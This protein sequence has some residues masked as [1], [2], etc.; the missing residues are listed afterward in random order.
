VKPRTKDRKADNRRIAEWL[1]CESERASYPIQRALRAA[2]RAAF[3]WPEEATDLIA[4]QRSLT[5][6][7]KVGPFLERQI[8]DWLANPPSEEA[9]PEMRQGFLT[10]TEAQ[11]ILAAK[12]EWK[13]ELKGDLQ[14]HTEWSDGS[15]PVREMARAAMERGYEYIAIT[16]HAKKLKIAGGITE[17]ELREQGREIEAINQDF[18]GRFR[19]LR[20][21][22]LNLDT[23]GNGDMAPAALEELD[24]VLG[25]FHSALRKTEDQTERYLGA[26]KNPNLHILGHPRGRIFNYRLGLKADWKKVFGLA[27]KLDKAVEIDCYPDRQDLNVELLK[28]AKKAGV[29]ISLGTD[30]HHPWQLE[31]IDFGLAAAASAG[32][33][34]ER[35]L[36]FMTCDQLLQ[37]ARSKRK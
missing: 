27:A 3:L 7:S 19:I 21:I 16:D 20:S 36:N 2:G 30:A 35:V 15:A 26:L 9:V 29:R 22:E 14:M 4:Q 28:L 23:E 34:R 12:P 18:A 31:F 32:I 5:E 25:A 13:K 6:L 11:K 37:W 10:W 33:R 1:A 24:L 8:R 17:A